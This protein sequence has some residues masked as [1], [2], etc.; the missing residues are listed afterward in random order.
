MP[1]HQTIFVVGCPTVFQ[2]VFADGVHNNCLFNAMR[3]GLP[4]HLES[5]G[6]W[7]QPA[8]LWRQ[9]V[10]TNLKLDGAFG[11]ADSKARAQT[12]EIFQECFQP[13]QMVLA[14]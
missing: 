7:Q 3:Q 13:G 4:N 10:L 2:E 5:P 6:L 8:S 11:F 9:E 1:A 14:D 12:I